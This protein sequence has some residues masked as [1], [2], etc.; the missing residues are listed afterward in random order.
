MHVNS[1]IHIFW[2]RKPWFWERALSQEEK[3]KDLFWHQKSNTRQ[4]FKFESSWV[5]S[6][7]SI[8][9][10]IKIT[11]DPERKH[12]HKGT[13]SLTGKYMRYLKT[14]QYSGFF[15]GILDYLKLTLRLLGIWVKTVPE[16]RGF[17]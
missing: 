7:I 1:V 5:A 16:M 6:E 8:T 4:C 12:V 17:L 11:D 2:C 15:H 13:E 10:M 14:L 9:Y 3:P